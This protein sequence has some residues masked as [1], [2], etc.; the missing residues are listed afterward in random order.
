MSVRSRLAL[1]IASL[2][3][4]AIIAV[5]AVA[6]AIDDTTPP[7]T[8]DSY[9]GLW[10]NRDVT[11]TLSAVDDISGVAGTEYST[12]GVAYV[13]GTSFLVAALTV[14]S[15][16]HIVFYRS[17]DYAGNAETPKSCVV[18]IDTQAP[19]ASVSG[20]DTLWHR[21]PVTLHV[22]AV[23]QTDLSGVKK[24]GYRIDK[25]SWTWAAWMAPPEPAP[26]IAVKAP[27][28]HSWDG[29]HTAYYRAADSAGNV[30]AAKSV[31]VKIDTRGPACS[32]PS[33]VSAVQ[34]ATATLR[35][36]VSD[37]LSAKARVTLKI[38][39]P[40]G[41]TV[42]S[43][44][45]GWRRTNKALSYRVKCSYSPG[46]YRYCVYAVDLAGNKQSKV[47]VN[48]LTVRPAV[49]SSIS[50]SV[51][52]SSPSQYSDVTAYCKAKDQAGRPL[53]GVRVTFTWHYKTTTPSE[54]S[55]TS[56]SGVASC[57]R[58]ISGATEGYRVIITITASYRGVTKTA[59][60]SF[61]PW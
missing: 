60:T 18:R 38:K 44:R 19:S 37:T 45:L 47:G 42:K 15:G 48:A 58:Y 54:S 31:K 16:E 52:D 4:M 8:T 29:V 3:A 27:A 9:D 32:A 13:P 2:V 22:A 23:D 46:T 34:N 55:A 11:V 35:Y 61:T 41:R 17:T 33:A 21:K 7:V 10:H 14:G 56:S 50:A 1:L 36:R 28:N 25:R 20:A 30:S 43:I 12:D 5:P 49:L 51:S 26:V 39:N 40:R 57:T 53:S 6:G 59:S 24:Y